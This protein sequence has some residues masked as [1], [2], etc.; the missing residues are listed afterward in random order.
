MRR[1]TLTLVTGA[2][3]IAT[4]AAGVAFATPGV[5]TETANV[6]GQGLSGPVVSLDGATIQRSDSGISVRLTMPTPE[7]GSYFYPGTDSIPG[8]PLQP[9]ATGPVGF[10][11]AVPGHP[12]AYS[13]WVFV[14]NDPSVCV[15]DPCTIA[16]FNA[17][18]GTAGA[19]NAGGHL[20]GGATLQLSG[21]VMLSSTP[22]A[23]AMLTNPQGAEVHLAVAPH[24]A[25]DPALLPQMINLP[26][27]NPPYWWL[28]IFAL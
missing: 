9:P 18:L 13:L 12:E 17:N 6:V 7:P 20:V 26:I 25:L 15:G 4:I 22:F 24:G 21:R 3:A 27:G 11:P 10:P 16:D 23:G 1:R 28:A 5:T 2:A 19:F 14:F 8:N